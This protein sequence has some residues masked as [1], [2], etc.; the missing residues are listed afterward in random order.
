MNEEE[1]KNCEIK[2]NDILI[3]F[4]YFHKFKNKGKYKIKYI[5]KQFLT[6]TDYMFFGCESLKNIDLSNF[7]TQNVTNMEGMFW[8]CESLKKGA[9]ITKDTK[10]IEELK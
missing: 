10:I 2:I 9:V 8:V 4:T 6:K 3:P 7:N 1:I 5:F